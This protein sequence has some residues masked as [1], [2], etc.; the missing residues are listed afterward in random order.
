[1]KHFRSRSA[2]ITPEA[3]CRFC[4][5]FTPVQTSLPGSTYSGSGGTDP[6]GKRDLSRKRA[7]HISP[8]SSNKS[9][10]VPLGYNRKSYP[11][12][13][14]CDAWKPHPTCHKK[15]V[16]VTS[17]VQVTGSASLTTVRSNNDQK[18]LEVQ[19]NSRSPRLGHID[20]HRDD[21]NVHF[22]NLRGVRVEQSRR[23]VP[24]WHAFHRGRGRLCIRG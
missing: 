15:V 18:H 22:D 20:F 24:R 10:L 23:H 6:A 9:Y 17:T 3:D 19:T 2:L 21:H 11:Q 12:G 8:R 1:L 7:R 14:H 5:T 13:V 4:R 16:T